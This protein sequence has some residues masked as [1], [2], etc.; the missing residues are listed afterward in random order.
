MDEQQ[1][2]EKK[3]KIAIDILKQ[4]CELKNRNKGDFFTCFVS[5]VFVIN[6]PNFLSTL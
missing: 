3:W 2:K 1:L 5:C 4:F 6:R